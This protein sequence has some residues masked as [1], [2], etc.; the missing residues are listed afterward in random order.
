VAKRILAIETT[1]HKSSIN[2]Q[3]VDF[4]TSLLDGS[5]SDR[6]DMIPYD[7]VLF[8]S[9]K[10]HDDGV[11]E[12]AV[13]FREMLGEYDGC[14]ISLAEHNGSY[15]AVFKNLMDW[16]SV[17]EGKVWQQ[18]PVLLLSTSPGKRGGATVLGVAE[19][20]FPYMG[21]QVTGGFSLGSFHD[22]FEEG[23][24]ITDQNKLAELKDKIA[25]FEA[26]VLNT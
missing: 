11:P 4:A 2:K 13:R 3:L 14:I 21:A 16:V 15:T 24:G 19:N 6:I 17:L 18:K 10:H 7:M 20:Y 23:Q 8:S 26:A 12:Q 22:A 1:N 25:E 5:E 9:D